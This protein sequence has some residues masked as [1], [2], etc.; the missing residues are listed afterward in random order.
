M[1][2]LQSIAGEVVGRSGASFRQLSAIALN[3]ARGDQ[4][5]VI[6]LVFL[7]GSSEPAFLVKITPDPAGG[8]RLESEYE[9]LKYLQRGSALLRSAVPRPACLTEID[10]RFVFAETAFAGTR[11]KNFPPDRYFASGRFPEDLDRVVGWLVEFHRTGSRDGSLPPA[12]ED[13]LGPAIA[14]YRAEFEVS[15]ALDALLDATAQ[16]LEAAPVL[17]CPWHEDFC[18]ANVLV[19]DSGSGIQVIDW[20]HPLRLSWPLADLLHFLNSVW[21]VPYARGQ[22]AKE[23]NYRRLLFDRHPLERPVGEALR[24]Y[25][26]GLELQRDLLLPLSVMSW[27]AHAN[28]KRRRLRAIGAGPGDAAKHWPLVMLEGDRCLNLEILAE[29]SPSYILS[30]L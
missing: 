11:M 10:G 13:R 30:A 2:D 29:L 5:L 25:V 17:F 4:D 3:R 24:R 20:E 1:D 16:K 18:T 19:A 7:D 14:D 9:N 22:A 27:V 21:C 15:P 6:L 8:R 12:E 28:R 23:A 26:D